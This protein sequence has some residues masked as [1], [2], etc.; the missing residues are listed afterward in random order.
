MKMSR[1]LKEYPVTKEEIVALLEDYKA[2]A[3]RRGGIGDMR[4]TLLSEAIKHVRGSKLELSDLGTVQDSG[5]KVG[6]G[7]KGGVSD[8]RNSHNPLVRDDQRRDQL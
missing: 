4:P 6:G 7:R 2:L 1:N 5:Q 8:G 3:L